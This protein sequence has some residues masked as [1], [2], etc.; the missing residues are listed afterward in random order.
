MSDTGFDSSQDA[1]EKTA[2]PQELYASLYA[3]DAELTQ[4][5]DCWQRLEMPE[6]KILVSEAQRLASIAVAPSEVR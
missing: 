5:I 4:L 2:N 1:M 6:R 3:H